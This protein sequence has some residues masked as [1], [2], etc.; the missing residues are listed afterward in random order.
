MTITCPTPAKSRYATNQAADSA[1]SRV[2]IPIGQHLR[3]YECPCGWWHLTSQPGPA[4]PNDAT[5]QTV[6]ELDTPAFEDLVRR[7]LRGHATPHEAGALRHPAIATRWEAALLLLRVDLEGQFARRKE[8]RSLEARDW[9]RRATIVRATLAIRRKEAR[10]ARH[11]A[12]HGQHSLPTAEQQA[13][14]RL[15]A[16]RRAARNRHLDDIVGDTRTRAEE[17]ELRRVAGEAAI[18]RLIDAHGTEFTQYLTE[19]CERVGAELPNRVRKHL[20]QPAAA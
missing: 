4:T 1:A 19:E 2:Q 12:G 6:A 17:K 10:G 13:A 11:R 8:D 7:D 18:K 20:D 16:D 14:A 5:I 9:R 3:P 15:N